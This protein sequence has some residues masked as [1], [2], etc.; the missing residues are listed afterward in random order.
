MHL[1][2]I[3]HAQMAMIPMLADGID[4][5]YVLFFGLGVLIP[6]MLFQVG[7][8]SWV[9]S[10][11]WRMP[12]QGLWKLTF[13][14]NCVSLLAGIPTK[15]FNAWIYG[16]LLPRDLPGYFERYPWAIALGSFLYFAVTVAAEGAWAVRWLRINSVPLDTRSIW[17]GILLANVATYIVL[18]PLHYYLTQPTRDVREYS[19]STSWTANPTAKMLF[20]DPL[21]GHLKSVQLDGSNLKTIVSMAVNDYL[22]STNLNLCLFRGTDNNLYFCGREPAQTN[23]I[24]RTGEHFT[25]HQVAF[26]PSG[27]YVAYLSRN[28]NSLDVVYL[29]TMGTS[30]HVFTN[31]LELYDPPSVA[32]STNETQFY[33]GGFRDKARFRVTRQPAGTLH[34]EELSGT[35]PPPT[36]VCYGRIGGPG[37]G[38][39]DDSGPSYGSDTCGTLTVFTERGLGSGLRLRD[40]TKPVGSF[41]TISVNPGLFPFGQFGFYNASF[42]GDCRECVFQAEDYLYLLDIEARRV[43]TLTRG[44]RFILLTPRFQKRL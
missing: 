39:S 33:V 10:K 4:I 12:V 31:K 20:T 15:I 9:L 30:H 37:S 24:W 44:S 13:E 17:K 11:S 1:G 14:A 43:G 40:A 35:N 7:V 8:E 41:L 25:M 26:S 42:I 36:L 32:W 23:P 29:P 22:V 2:D 19:R 6:L 16:H 21:D 5:A 34:I 38:H 18:A 3:S 28:G 27:Q